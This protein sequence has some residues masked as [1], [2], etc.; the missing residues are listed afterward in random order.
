M[1]ETLAFG[2]W[3]G[4][5]R[6]EYL[7]LKS[8]MEPSSIAIIG[9][10]SE[11]QK[12]G[13]KLVYNIKN[14]DFKGDIWIV[15]PKSPSVQDLPTF[16]SIKD[17][18]SEVDLGMITVAAPFVKQS[19][20]ELIEKGVKGVIIISCGFGE[21][22]EKGKKEE[23]ELAEIAARANIPMIGP[24]CMGVATFKYAGVFAGPIPNLKP[25]TIDFVSGSGA[26]AA[27]ILE[28]AIT[29]GVSFSSEIT[30]GNSAMIGIEEVLEYWD[31]TFS[32][33]TSSRV[34]MLYME[35]LTKPQK[36]IKHSRSLREKGC[37]LVAIKA[38][39]T[40]AGTRAASSHTGAMASSDTSIDAL[41]RKAQVIRVQSKQELVYTAGILESY[42]P[43]SG[44]RACIVT[45]AGGPGVMLTDE[46][47]RQGFE[48]PKIAQETHDKLLANLL[49]G[50]AAGNPVDFLAAGTAE[51]LDF[52][53]ESLRNE[54]YID[55]I[56][57]IFGSPGLFDVWPVYKV[58]A[59]KLPDYPKPI[60][61]VFPS[62]VTAKD[63]IDKF[64]AR[65]YMCIPEEV[66]LGKTLGR[67]AAVPSTRQ[68]ERKFSDIDENAISSIL[69]EAEGESIKQLKAEKI[70]S[71]L[72]ALKIP[73]PFE[74]IA[75]SR[76][77]GQ[78]IAEKIGYPVVMKVVGPVHKS[79]VGGV[80]IGIKNTQEMESAL[81]KLMQ[82]KD[83]EGVLFQEMA[84]GTEVIIGVSREEGFGHLIMFG[85][86]GIYTEILKDVIFT[87]APLSCEEAASMIKS[88]KAYKLL[89]GVRGKKGMNTEMLADILLR[90]SFLVQKF[91][92]IK[93]MDINPLM[94]YEDRILAVDTRI[95]I[96]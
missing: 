86:G 79:D 82:I 31:E 22:D 87:L 89:E 49:P 32:P 35:T 36:F 1:D 41:L 21:I 12:P 75:K 10:S 8:I 39:A 56:P 20:L 45:H 54:D 91:P 95:E 80:Y 61:P 34:K 44:K 17:L 90:I 96:D 94:G 9:G 46:L 6:K 11:I 85:L 19:L 88:I 69:K 67:I 93:E 33:D 42:K 78:E 5:F 68:T 76:S 28:L 47:S 7:M 29:L 37:H 84:K 4:N 71:I 70:S 83:A 62:T 72:K 81:D 65:G 3:T 27:F 30:I 77:E 74:A 50:S 64:L 26:T 53:L 16:K 73:I 66:N 13:G 52:I 25:K 51:N 40:E 2:N 43:P 15:N 24:N 14:H 38:G 59:D 60:Y 92:Q 23:Q 48:L 58:I 18:P 57:V 63:A 55:F